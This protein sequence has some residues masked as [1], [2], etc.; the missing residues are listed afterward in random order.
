MYYKKGSVF[1]G[2]FI[3]GVPFGRGRLIMPNGAHYEGE[4]R[5]GKANGQGV[6]ID[7]PYSYHGSFRD[8]LKHGEG[9]EKEENSYTFR[10]VFDSGEKVSGILRYNN[11]YYEG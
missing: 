9:E 10:G 2:S 11:C 4:V 8:D 3:E 5:Y 1:Y 6:F 7:G